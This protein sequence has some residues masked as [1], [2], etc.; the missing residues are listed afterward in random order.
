MVIP[1]AVP[2]SSHARYGRTRLQSSGLAYWRR[3]TGVVIHTLEERKKHNDEKRGG[4]VVRRRV[5][6]QAPSPVG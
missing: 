1:P 3:V 6:R 2:A 4:S 5:E